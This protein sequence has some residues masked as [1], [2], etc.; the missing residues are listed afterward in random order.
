VL[1]E[2]VE[3]GVR[4]GSCRYPKREYATDQVQFGL[5]QSVVGRKDPPKTPKLKIQ[6]PLKTYTYEMHNPREI[7]LPRIIS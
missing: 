4:C 3:D 1:E 5:R 2:V 7:V 6:K